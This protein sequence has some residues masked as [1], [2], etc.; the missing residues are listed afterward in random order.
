MKR[1]AL[2]FSAL[3]LALISCGEAATDVPVQTEAQNPAEDKETTAVTEEVSPLAHLGTHDFGGETMTFYTRE[4]SSLHFRLNVEESDGTVL[5]DALFE[6]CRRLED[7][8][9]FRYAEIYEQGNTTQARAAVMAGD[10]AYDVITTRIVYAYNYAAEGLLKPVTELPVVDLSKPYWDD[11]LNQNLSIGDKSYFAVGAFNL[12]GYDYSHMLVFNKG[13]VS[14]F[15]LGDMYGIVKGGKWTMDSMQNM[16]KAVV[17]DLDGNSTMDDADRYGLLATSKQ[18]LP[19]V[20]IA[21]G[22][23]SIKKDAKNYPTF[24]FGGDQGFADAF[25]RAFDLAYTA[26]AWRYTKT[27]EDVDPENVNLFIQ[28]QGLFMDMTASYLETLRT[29]DMDF[30]IIPYPKA[31]E[32]QKNYCTR[33]EGCELFC[34]PVTNERMEFT[35]LVL[36]AMAAD[37]YANVLPVYYDVM[38]KSKYTRDTESEQMIDL[39]F[40]NRVLDWGDTIWCEIIRDANFMT[41]MQKNDRDLASAAVSMQKKVEKSITETI[42]AFEALD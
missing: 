32:A 9:N 34:I 22:Q 12:T 40:G 39:I 13:L 27:N 30:G 38:L 31:D 8:Y 16:M 19:C 23:L 29:M 37:A 4:R 10:S 26:D 36:E 28:N 1:M 11:A 5:N 33:I 24:S 2:L 6:R 18:I 35:G 3:L 42:E 17:S 25:E 15:D 41:M 20:W 7:T 21:A 14:Q